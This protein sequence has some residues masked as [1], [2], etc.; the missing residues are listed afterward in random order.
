MREISTTERYLDIIRKWRLDGA[1]GPTLDMLGEI[2]MRVLDNRDESMF[3]FNWY[4]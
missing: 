3:D 1:S 2:S 4:R